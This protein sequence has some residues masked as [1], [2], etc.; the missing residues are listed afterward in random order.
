MNDKNKIAGIGILSGVFLWVASKIGKGRT[1]PV[2]AELDESQ[3]VYNT[4]GK[5][6][7]QKHE[8]VR[9]LTKSKS[10][11]EGNSFITD[12]NRLFEREPSLDKKSG[13]SQAYIGPRPESFFKER[14]YRIP[15]S[16][17]YIVQA[18]FATEKVLKAILKKFGGKKTGG[19]KTTD[20][21]YG[22]LANGLRVRVST[23]DVFTARSRSDISVVFD[24]ERETLYVNSEILPLSLE[25]KMKDVLNLV[26]EELK[27]WD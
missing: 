17:L 12:D 6:K 7:P 21:V 10:K 2:L 23:H 25:T 3:A 4:K 24:Y 18:R 11:K 16:K 20:S 13:A 26:K 14:E 1:N 9:Y 8:E 15:D 19:S 5:R 22:R 27:K